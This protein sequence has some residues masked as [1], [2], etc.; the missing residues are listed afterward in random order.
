[1]PSLAS[2]GTYQ[3]NDYPLRRTVS[4]SSPMHF[5]APLRFHTIELP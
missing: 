3:A 4:C 2:G 1:M 5:A